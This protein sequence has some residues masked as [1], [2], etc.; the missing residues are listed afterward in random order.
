M[1]GAT[2][3]LRRATIALLFVVA[4]GRA[5][6]A[7]AQQNLDEAVK[8]T[9]LYRFAAFADWPATAFSAP[10]APLVI[11]MTGSAE[12]AALVERGAAAHRVGLH[13]VQVRRLSRVG[14]GSGCHILFA[15]GAPSQGV[16][17]ALAAV[18][19]DSVL[20]VTDARYGDSRGIIHFVVADNRVRFH[21]DRTMA[22]NNRIALSSRLLGIALSVRGARP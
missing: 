10:D 20:T 22:E 5:L 9:F 7:A 8:A 1:A 13:P 2:Q 21:I 19:G 18:A 16:R 15:G 12:F 3:F 17:E 6:D 14:R 4:S 11:C